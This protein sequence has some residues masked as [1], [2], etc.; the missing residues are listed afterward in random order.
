MTKTM[1][2]L[3][4]AIIV[5][6]LWAAALAQAA[7]MRPAGTANR[8]VI[9]RVSSLQH[10]P[11]LHETITDRKL[12]GRIWKDIHTLKPVTGEGYACPADFGVTLD[13]SLYRG[14]DL[15]LSATDNVSGC[16]WVR[17][18]GKSWWP[19]E[20]FLRAIHQAL[21]MSRNQILGWGSR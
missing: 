3:T 2:I 5:P 6:L 15:V 18:K 17:F 21:G 9:A 14:R 20:D 1:Q 11:R 4:A 8:L 16:D 19:S 13:L 7:P 10:L 12:V